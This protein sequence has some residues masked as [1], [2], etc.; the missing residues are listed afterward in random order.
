TT[1]PN[2]TGATKMASNIGA[3][4]PTSLLFA[5]IHVKERVLVLMFLLRACYTVSCLLT[6]RKTFSVHFLTNI[7]PSGYLHHVLEGRFSPFPINMGSNCLRISICPCAK[8]RVYEVFQALKTKSKRCC[9]FIVLQFYFDT[10]NY[11]VLYCLLIQFCS[12]FIH[13]QKVKKNRSIKNQS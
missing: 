1:L 4:K 5:C 8:R 7:S 11:F 13:L 3:I 6:G 9:S 2:I 12:A 10:R